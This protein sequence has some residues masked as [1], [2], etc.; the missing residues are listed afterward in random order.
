LYDLS[1]FDIV[2]MV[3]RRGQLQ[4]RRNPWRSSSS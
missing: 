3:F 2:K 1:F 4:E